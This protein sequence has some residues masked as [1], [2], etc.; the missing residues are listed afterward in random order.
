MCN[1]YAEFIYALSISIRDRILFKGIDIG[2]A[3][4]IRMLLSLETALDILFAME[5]SKIPLVLDL[6]QAEART[7][8]LDYEYREKCRSFLR[9]LV[10]KHHVLPPSLFVQRI[11]SNSAHIVAVGGYSDIYRGTLESKLVCLKVLRVYV[12]DGEEKRNK[13]LYEFYKEALLWTQFDHPNILPF[14]GVNTTL[15][16]GKIAL[17]APWMANGQITK[18]LKANPLHDRLKVISEIAAGIVYLHSHNIVHGDIKGVG[19][20]SQVDSP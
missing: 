13:G 10:K 14:L 17:V 16:P 3:V 15:F 7:A 11:T 9:L 12:E 18:F 8:D 6:L 5:S 4:G 20:V 19:Q 2:T 1:L